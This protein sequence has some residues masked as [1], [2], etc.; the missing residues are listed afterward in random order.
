MQNIDL[1][2]REI[3]EI[4]VRSGG[5]KKVPAWRF[6]EFAARTINDYWSITHLPTGCSLGFL[7]F[8]IEDCIDAMME[9]S[10][11]KN[12]WEFLTLDEISKTADQAI[13]IMLNHGGFPAI[14]LFDLEAA[15]PDLERVNNYD[16]L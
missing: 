9:I 11:L 1:C 2:T 6:H 16:P 3:I 7:F 13:P 12:S 4:S 15:P 10:A 14:L 8:S 5:V